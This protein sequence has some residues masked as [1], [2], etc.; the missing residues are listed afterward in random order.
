MDANSM[1]EE[2]PNVQIPLLALNKF[3]R[4]ATTTSTFHRGI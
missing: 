4:S 1:H 2:I 3:N